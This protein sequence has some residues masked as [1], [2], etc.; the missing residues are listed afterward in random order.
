MNCH[1]LS[2]FLCRVRREATQKHISLAVQERQKVIARDVAVCHCLYNT[3]QYGIAVALQSTVEKRKGT[4]ESSL[5]LCACA[6]CTGCSKKV[7]P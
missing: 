7:A 2:L 1:Q 5:V 4:S 6:E 3:V